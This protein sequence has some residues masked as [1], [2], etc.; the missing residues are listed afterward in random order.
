MVRLVTYPPY[1]L[2]LFVAGYSG[3]AGA[4]ADEGQ[5]GVYTRQ[6]RR[7]ELNLKAL[8]FTLRYES[9]EGH[10]LPRS[11]L[12]A[13]QSSNDKQRTPSTRTQT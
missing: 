5:R 9:T 13:L 1:F 2:L 6:D 8:L 11:A 12:D 10:V 4:V 7:K 3:C